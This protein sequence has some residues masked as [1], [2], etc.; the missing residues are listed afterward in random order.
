MLS[1]PQALKAA[2]RSSIAHVLYALGLLQLWQ[3]V[4]LRNRT[5]VLMYHRVLDDHDWAR[6]GS[7]P[8]MTVRLS[9]FE[10]QMALLRRRLVPLSLERFVD[11]VSRRQPLPSS[12]CLITFDDGWRDTMTNAWPVLRRL[13]LPAAVFLPV[14]FIGTHRLFTREAFTH[15]A[16][17]ARDVASDPAQTTDL[18]AT[19]P[20]RLPEQGR[21]HRRHAR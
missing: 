9:T 20:E 8:G 13:G 16:L 10:R 21:W 4:Q 1:A 14:G 15:L 5:I 7:H 12:S 18:A 6:T 11:H 19:H 17:K 3:R 2:I